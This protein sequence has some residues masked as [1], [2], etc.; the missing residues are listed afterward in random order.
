MDEQEDGYSG[1][2]WFM[3]VIGTIGLF[4]FIVTAMGAG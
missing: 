1:L 4:G 2:F 3:L